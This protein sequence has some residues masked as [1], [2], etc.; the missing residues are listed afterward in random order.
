MQYNVADGED[1]ASLEVAKHLICHRRRR[2]DHQKGAEVYRYSDRARQH[3]K[4]L[5]SV[6]THAQPALGI[7]NELLMDPFKQSTPEL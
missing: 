7:I 2:P 4:C 6:N 1:E 3:Y 5:S